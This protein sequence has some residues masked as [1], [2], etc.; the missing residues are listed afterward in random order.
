MN[1]TQILQFVDRNFEA[2]QRVVSVDVACDALNRS[3]V[4]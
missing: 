3:M 1:F 4:E 2:M